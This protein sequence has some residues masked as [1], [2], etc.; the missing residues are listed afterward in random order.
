[1]SMT[2]L[3]SSVTAETRHEQWMKEF[4]RS[5]EDDAEKEKRF[6]IFAEK[7]EYIERFNRDGNET[8]ELGLNQFSD[9]T[10]EEFVSAYGCSRLENHLLESSIFNSSEIPTIELPKVPPK[11]KRSPPS[12]PPRPPKRRTPPSTPP[13]T[14]I[15]GRVNWREKGAVTIVKNQDKP[16][17][18]GSC[19][20]FAVTATVEGIMKIKQNRP[21][22]ALSA[23]ELIDCDQGNNGCDGGKASIAFEYIVKNG[24][25]RDVDYP[26]R[27]Q[28]LGCN[29]GSKRSFANI[30]GYA[31]VEAG[32]QNLL[33]AVARQPVAVYISADKHFE[34]YKGGIYGSG[35]CK[36]QTNL[37]VNHLVTVVGYEE[38]YW[39]IKN[40]YGTGWGETGYMKLKRQGSSP[41]PVCG[42]AMVASF[43]P[44]TF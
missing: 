5:Y 3:E 11:R 13:T 33:E 4:G 30:K 32:E 34:D 27:A 8:Y 26:Y 18:C 14:G 42:I 2:V 24:I 1:M 25:T 9:L 43:Y 35:P 39:L 22:V 20:A 10:Y 23:Q 44:T 29:R 6:K 36:P 31:K 28:K 37:K 38:D 17:Q 19:W 15:P 21:L 16:K 7:L 40:S 12:R 41:N